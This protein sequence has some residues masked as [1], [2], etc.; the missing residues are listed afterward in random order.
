[1][2]KYGDAEIR[3]W[4]DGRMLGWGNAGMPGCWDG[5]IRGRE[6]VVRHWKAG[7][8]H[9]RKFYWGWMPPHPTFFVRKR[10]YE[11]MVNC[12]L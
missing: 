5:G 3:K 4:G 8:F 1:M 6:R 11:K 9:P 7:E 2:V 12:E 10:V